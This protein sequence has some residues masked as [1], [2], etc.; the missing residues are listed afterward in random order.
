M[1][2]RG[3]K[4]TKCGYAIRKYALF[5][6]KCRSKLEEEVE[7]DLERA[8]GNLARKYLKLIERKKHE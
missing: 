5:C 2:G 4:C 7:G 1:P 8:L 3:F 6:P